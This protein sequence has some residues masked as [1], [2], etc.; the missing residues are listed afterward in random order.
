MTNTQ[1]KIALLDVQDEAKWDAFVDA[2]KNAT[3]YHK[4]AWMRA[5]KDA[6]GFEP[7]AIAAWQSEELVGVLPLVVMSSPFGGKS[8]CSLPYCDA[9][10]ILATSD[11]VYQAIQTHVIAMA[12]SAGWKT[13]ELRFANSEIKDD[14]EQVAKVRMLLDLPDTSELLMASFKSKLRSQIRKAEKNGLTASLG[15]DAKH[16]DGFYQVYSRNMRDLGSPAHSFDWFKSVIN[17]FGDQ[18]MIACVYF[19]EQV[20]GGGLII[21]TKDRVSIPW[22]STNADFNRLAPNML[23]Y[24]TLLEHVN[25]SGAKM[26]D[27]GR[28][29]PGEGTFKFK[30][31]WG[32]QPAPLDWQKLEGD[33]FV[34][35]GNVKSAP[36]STRQKVEMLWRKLPVGLATFVGS[37]VRKYISL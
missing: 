37:N 2:D 32:A 24:W 36:S 34:S 31:Q 1:L 27:F 29:T 4:T 12:K 18:A 10:G 23:L 21:R 28:S 6:Y 26:F 15:T 11:E 25:D 16:L 33:D 20:V 17:A 13:T 35:F 5:V 22:A 30:K 14:V 7:K 3:P 9:G 19:E 8:A